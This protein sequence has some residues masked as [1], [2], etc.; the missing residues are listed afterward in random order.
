[1]LCAEFRGLRLDIHAISRRRITGFKGGSSVKGRKVG[2]KKKR[3]ALE[4]GK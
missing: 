4:E 1:L 2:G 3:K